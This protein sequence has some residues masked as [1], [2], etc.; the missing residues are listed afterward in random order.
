MQEIPWIKTINEDSKEL[1]PKLQEMYKE[2]A[3]PTGAVD[4]VLKIHS[5]HP[6]SLRVQWEF[7]TMVMRGI[8]KLSL[9]QREMIAVKVSSANGCHY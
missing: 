6:E 2:M 9:V 7:Y 3:G 5:L 1:T 8:S 4:N